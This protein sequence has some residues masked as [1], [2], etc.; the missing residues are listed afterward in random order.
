VI[1]PQNLSIVV[2]DL[3]ILLIASQGPTGPALD[4][5]RRPCRMVSPSRGGVKPFKVCFL[6]VSAGIQ[7]AP[8]GRW[9][10]WAIAPTPVGV[11]TRS[12]DDRGQAAFLL[13][14]GDGQAAF[15]S[16]RSKNQP[17]P[18][19]NQPVL[20]L[21]LPLAGV[22]APAGTDSKL[23][24]SSDIVRSNAPAGLVEYRGPDQRIDER[25]RRFLL[26]SHPSG[27]PVDLPCLA[28]VWKW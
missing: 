6:S 17:V 13:R 18:R 1:S 20:A 23:P 5:H 26:A 24:T 12:R 25:C 28:S 4:Y 21:T 8:R 3:G 16:R 10:P 27:V 19:K 11:I 7:G 9:R 2:H 14:E 22:P 15:A